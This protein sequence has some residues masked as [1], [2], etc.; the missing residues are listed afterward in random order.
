ML[1]M[2]PDTRPDDRAD[3]RAGSVPRSR[4]GTTKPVSM[5]DVAAHAGVSAQTV[6][7]VSNGHHGV[8]EETRRRVLDSMRT[9]GYRPNSAARA[10]KWGEFRTMGVITFELMNHGI[11]S[12][13]DAISRAAAAEGYAVTLLPAGSS[14]QQD[15]RHAFSRLEEVAVDAI[16]IL[17]EEDLL[18]AAQ[19]TLPPGAPALFAA[20]VE[21]PL[22]STVDADQFGGAALATE[23]LLTLGH[24]TVHHLAGPK[25]ALSAERRRLGWRRTLQAH[26]VEAPPAVHGDWSAVAGYELGLTM[27]ED[28]GC[29]A[30]FCA[31]DQT[32]LGLYRAARERGRRIPDDLSI[33]G[34]DDTD[35]ASAY[36]PPLTTVAQNFPEVGRLAVDEVLRRLRDPAAPPEHPVVP[37]ELILRASTAPPATAADRT[38]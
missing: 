22:H 33:V 8:L 35:D 11:V 13:V 19:I 26:G 27:L 15:V 21:A 37:T 5:A 24:R 10:L 38:S 6:S 4:T 2:T 12:T 9:L 16:I 14:A 32:A 17:A 7:R 25:D 30:V 23:H 34:F 31:N 3:D 36:D 29:T 28:P 1:P 20:P 18:D